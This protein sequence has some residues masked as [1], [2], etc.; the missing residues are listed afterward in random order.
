MYL[1]CTAKIT[2]TLV[3]LLTRLADAVA[4]DASGNVRFSFSHC[5]P[6]SQ[7]EG[8]FR[9]PMYGLCAYDE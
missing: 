4:D 5:Q 8:D 7:L 3:L 6:I 9:H 1:K 2:P